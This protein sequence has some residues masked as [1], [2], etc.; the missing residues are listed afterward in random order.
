MKKVTSAVL[1]ALKLTWKMA[2]LTILLGAACQLFDV[3]RE[4]MPG[5]VPIQAGFGFETLAQ[6]GLESAGRFWNA[7]LLIHLIRAAAATRGSKAVYTLNRLG[8]DETALFLI[9]GLVFTGYFLLYWALQIALAY[10]VFAWYTRCAIVSSNTWMLACWRSEWLHILLPLEE[11][12]GWLRNAVICLSFGFSAAFGARLS[13]R[14]K[15]PLASLIP[16]ALCIF[17]LDGT[18]GEMGKALILTALLTAFTAGY[19]FS[20][21]G[22]LEDEDL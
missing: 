11:W 5:G 21:K 20:V 12:W 15:L 19:F 7:L 1:L 10:G 18:I 22:V 14:G 13:L 6:L 16:P 17:L 2:V 9:F 4:L 8:L 3:G